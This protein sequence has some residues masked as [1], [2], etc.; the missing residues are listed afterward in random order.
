MSVEGN[1]FQPKLQQLIIGGEITFKEMGPDLNS[2]PL[3]QDCFSTRAQNIK[4]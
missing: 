4:L 2:R 3:S 1:T